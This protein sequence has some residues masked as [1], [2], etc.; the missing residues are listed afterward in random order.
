[1]LV[2]PGFLLFFRWDIPFSISLFV[3]GLLMFSLLYESLNFLF[4]LCEV[5]SDKGKC[6]SDFG[7]LI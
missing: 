3:K 4:S 5:S 6:D 7:E 2:G 1:M